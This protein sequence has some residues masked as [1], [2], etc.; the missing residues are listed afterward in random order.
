MGLKARKNNGLNGSE[1]VCQFAQFIAEKMI[2]KIRP[3]RNWLELRTFADRE[4]M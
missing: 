3:A 2:S 4:A 1:M